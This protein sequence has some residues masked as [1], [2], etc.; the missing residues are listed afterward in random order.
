LLQ[1][2]EDARADGGADTEHRQLE[3]ADTSLQ[4]IGRAMRDRRTDDGPAPEHLLGE[5]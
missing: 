2:D 5:A 4:V 3:G 1:H